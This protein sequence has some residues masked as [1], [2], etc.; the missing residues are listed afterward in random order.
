MPVETLPYTHTCGFTHFRCLSGRSCWGKGL[1]K[2]RAEYKIMAVNDQPTSSL[3]ALHGWMGT[4][5]ECV[6]DNKNK[7]VAGRK[8]YFLRPELPLQHFTL[9]LRGYTGNGKD[10]FIS[11]WSGRSRKQTQVLVFFYLIKTA[12]SRHLITKH[13]GLDHFLY[14]SLHLSSLITILLD[15]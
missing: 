8:T 6:C 1:K 5:E 11:T 14:I 13:E 9:P 2:V 3:A 7:I 15:L 10:R 4:G 12:K